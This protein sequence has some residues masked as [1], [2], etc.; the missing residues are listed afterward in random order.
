MSRTFILVV[1]ATVSLVVAGV[2][3]H[4][5]QT[6][7]GAPPTVIPIATPTVPA[8]P[9]AVPAS[10]EVAR[11][12]RAYALAATNWTAVTYRTAYRR[13]RRLASLSLASA[14]RRERPSPIQL[15]QLREDRSAR[16]G[17]IVRIREA[18]DFGEERRVLLDVD[19]LRTGAGQRSRQTVSYEVR[20]AFERGTLRVA[21]FTSVGDAR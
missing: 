8:T 17:A 18:T 9:T 5:Q 15:R 6:G 13:R 20:L 10:S 1:I 2:V 21:G 3:T 11:M 4:S 19:E 12:A 14:L 7:N 16:L